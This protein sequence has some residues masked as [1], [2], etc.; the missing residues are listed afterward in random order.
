MFFNTEKSSIGL[1]SSQSAQ[2]PIFRKIYFTPTTKNTLPTQKPLKNTRSHASLLTKSQVAIFPL[3]KSL[4]IPSFD[5]KKPD[6]AHFLWMRVKSRFKEIL[7]KVLLP[8][9]C[10]IFLLMLLVGIRNNLIEKVCFLDNVVCRSCNGLIKLFYMFPIVSLEFYVP[11]LY[12]YYFLFYS[13]K[14]AHFK[15]MSIFS[16][17]LYYLVLYLW[18][19][20]WDLAVSENFPEKTLDNF[21]YL[22]ISTVNV[23]IVLPLV[24]KLNKLS[25]LSLFK[26]TKYNTLLVGMVS[27]TFILFINIL[28]WLQIELRKRGDN[29]QNLYQ[30]ILVIFCLAYESTLIYIMIKRHPS[31]LE[32]WENNNCPLLFISKNILIFSYAIRL[33]N[34]SVLTYKVFGFYL[35]IIT[36]S[37]Y[38]IETL[39][40]TSFFG[41]LMKKTKGFF[42]NRRKSKKIRLKTQKN[43]ENCKNL[44]CLRIMSYQKIEFTLIYVPR[45]LYIITF[46]KWS[47][48]LP[49]I[50][51]VEGCSFIINEK[52]KIN[53]VNLLI[54]IVIDVI[55]TMFFLKRTI[56]NHKLL[57]YIRFEAEDMPF[58]TKVALYMGFQICF[59]YWIHYYMNMI[60]V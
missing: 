27:S 32:D 48:S 42:E 38:V 55:L 30:I 57:K 40:G 46:N 51:L 44:L 37:I 20:I 3:Q 1:V 43:M 58:V 36:F 47:L 59:E 54:L 35:Q 12:G 50:K 11:I 53:S 8:H 39:Y 28:N 13:N 14:I 16:M 2:S 19:F 29:Y 33:A 6:F 5:Q 41:F 52:I 24:K 34:I 23:I 4:S 18:F 25:W 45:I 9:F 31:L 21:I 49:F 26:K 7:L 56:N 60:Y 15:K 10:A 22:S 17:G